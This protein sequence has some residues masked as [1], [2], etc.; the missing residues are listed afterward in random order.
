MAINGGCWVEQASMITEACRENGY[1]LLRGRCY[2]P[3]LAPP[4][5]SLPTSSPSEAP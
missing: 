5:K 2:A 4:K 1:V 3:A